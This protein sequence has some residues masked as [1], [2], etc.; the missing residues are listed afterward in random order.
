MG[1]VGQGSAVCREISS[2]FPVS[3]EL[4]LKQNYVL[5]KR[6]QND[7]DLNDNTEKKNFHFVTS[8]INYLP[9]FCWFR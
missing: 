8:V 4:E 6:N 3:I 1:E 5:Q 7:L 9:Q 2:C